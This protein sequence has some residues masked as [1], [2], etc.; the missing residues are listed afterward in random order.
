[1]QVEHLDI[2]IYDP[3]DDTWT[4]AKVNMTG[5]RYGFCA[6][7]DLMENNLYLTG[8]IAENGQKKRLEILDLDSMTW[9]RGPDMTYGRSFHGCTRFGETGLIVAGGWGDQGPLD[10]VE[11]FDSE[12][13]QELPAMNQP[14]AEFSLASHFNLEE[15]VTAFGGFANGSPLDS[16]ETFNHQWSVHPF[17][18]MTRAKS[19]FAIV[20][21][22]E[23]FSIFGNC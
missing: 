11:L 19:S 5:T 13:W 15:L 17:Q 8:G 2:E 22:P 20:T 9:T 3:Q 10:K 18:I 12:S 16:I 7:V 21:I 4:L 23:T 1:M 14:R 6:S